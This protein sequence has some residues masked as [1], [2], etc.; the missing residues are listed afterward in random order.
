MLNLQWRTFN[1]LSAGELYTALALRQDVF[2]LEQRCL[3]PDIDGL[4]EHATHLLGLV[5]QTLAGYIRIFPKGISY[6]DATSFGRV[7]TAMQFRRQGLA[8]I[9][10]LAAISFLAQLAPQDPIVI[11]AQSYLQ[12]FYAGLGFKAEGDE[13]LEDGIPHLQ[14][15]YHHA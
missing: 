2:I 8:K 1:E 3:Y 12:T 6:P 5:N 9:M 10:A 4:D 11:S 7:A 13:Y 15:R 14:M